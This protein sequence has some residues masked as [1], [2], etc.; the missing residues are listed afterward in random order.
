MAAA[1]GNRTTAKM[2]NCCPTVA[3]GTPASYGIGDIYNY[4]Y[5]EVLGGGTYGTVVKAEDLRSGE[6]VAVKWIRPDDK[7]VTDMDAV[8]Y[9]AA[10]LEACRGHPSIVQMKE[11]VYEAGTGH[12][13]I[14][15]EFVGPSLKSDLP[16][17]FS[18]AETRAIM[19]QLLRGAE[20]LHSACI[21]HRDIKPDNILVGPGG[22][23]KICDLGMAV[24]TR[25]P[26]EPHSEQTVA[27]LWYRAPELMGRGRY[28]GT[29]VDMWALGCVMMELLMGAPLFEDA[30]TEDDVLRRALAMQCQMELD[31]MM[32]DL[33]ASKPQLV[34]QL[35]KAG[36][37]VLQGLLSF[38]AEKRLTAADAL[39]H[40]WFQE[41]EFDLNLPPPECELDLNLTL[42]VSGWT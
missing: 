31:S 33:V 35:S 24:A 4:R 19:R 30:N 8:S 5:I 23:L 12:V 27:A 6:T 18:E 2:T 10:Y 26:G 7:G 42:G 17:R 32:T 37:E 3:G 22:A 11:L 1:T 38:V 15:M 9:E 36:H 21:I 13:F 28:Y 40:R 39:N 14:V 41:R 34:P 20:K 25:A 29:A 16:R